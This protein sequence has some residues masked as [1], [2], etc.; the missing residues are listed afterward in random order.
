MKTNNW[1]RGLEAIAAT[2]QHDQSWNSRSAGWERET[3]VLQW[4][5]RHHVSTPKLLT[6]VAGSRRR[7]YVTRLERRGLV[8]RIPWASIHG[9]HL[10]VLTEI[11]VAESLA[12]TGEDVPYDLRADRAYRPQIVHALAGQA[13]VLEHWNTLT[14][15]RPERL[16]G[17]PDQS[18]SKRPDALIE[19]EGQWLG[20]EV[21][22]SPKS[23]RDLD[24]AL[25]ASAA[26]IDA[27]EVHGVLWYFISAATATRYRDTYQRP[28]ARW[29]KDAENGKWRKQDSKRVSDA[30]RARTKF[31]V[32]NLLRAL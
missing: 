1:R 22:L 8:K 27:G 21:E 31:V 29:T 32:A 17:E 10:V 5:L 6:R 25:Q 15:Y 12:R 14:G 19:I 11:G 20:V 18:G 26:M 7:G 24:D 4:L 23:G 2:R 30:A 13:A 9:R 28:I 16:M 3:S